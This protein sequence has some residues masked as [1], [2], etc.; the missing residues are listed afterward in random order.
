MAT[1]ALYEPR[2]REN[3]VEIVERLHTH[4]TRWRDEI[5]PSGIVAVNISTSL[6]L[7]MER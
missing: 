1:R 2:Q 5:R 4:R 6:A 3:Q 7:T